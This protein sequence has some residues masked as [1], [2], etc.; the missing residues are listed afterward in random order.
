M[1]TLALDGGSSKRSLKL[2]VMVVSSGA[3]AIR[4]E[5]AGDVG[6]SSA[7]Q[8]LRSPGW[9]KIE[10][11]KSVESYAYVRNSGTTRSELS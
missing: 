6:H 7:C 2:S 4:M 9:S 8:G 5:A 11:K 3:G 10:I 1:K